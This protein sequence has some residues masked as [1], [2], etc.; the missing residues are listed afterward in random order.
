VLFVN[1]LNDTSG[2][3]VSFVSLS[4]SE[5]DQLEESFVASVLAVPPLV[6]TDIQAL[7]VRLVRGE[8]SKCL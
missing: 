2:N 4:E 5:R 7:T 8:S 6:S 1:P 3:P